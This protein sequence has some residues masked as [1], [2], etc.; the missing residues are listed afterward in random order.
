VAQG[1]PAQ[2]RCVRVQ[3]MGGKQEQMAYGS[4]SKSKKFGNHGDQRK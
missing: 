2:Q 1:E 3:A 4:S